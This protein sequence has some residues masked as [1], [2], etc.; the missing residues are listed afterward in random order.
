MEIKQLQ[1]FSRIAE[2][3][4]LTRAASLL[5]LTQ[6]ALSRQVA[7]LE[8]E[9]GVELFR[10]NGRGL[11]L[12]EAGLR[13]REHVPLVLRQLALAERAVRGK[14]H[15][16]QGT[17]ALGLPPS[18][19]RTAVI[20]LIDA[21]KQELPEVTLRTVD[22]L[23]AN[24]IELVGMGKLDCAVIYSQAPSDS[25]QLR[26]LAEEDLYLVSGPL[27]VLAGNSP[28]P[29]SISLTHVASL[30]LVTAGTSNAIHA[31]LASAL[32]SLGLTAQ[33]AHQIENLTA[34]LD[35]VRKG[36]GCSVI[37]LS[38][39]RPCIGDT[40]LRLHRIRKPILRCSLSI[41]TAT[42]SSNDMLTERSA[43]VVF[44]VVRR[45][46]QQFHADVEE[47]IG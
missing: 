30:P 42:G 16:I 28:P 39:V 14:G 23:S 38:G 13:L 25:V 26:P 4:N 37:P 46:L 20:P 32:A 8:A 15:P 24:L 6:A 21:F 7:Q 9:L 40:E 34:I 44:D 19:A 35:L 10:R 11:V 27:A 31:V 2:V 18:L 29:K 47:A 33:V 17:L 43:S 12:T 5:G 45:Q 1:N 22:G 3:G 41:A 36:Y